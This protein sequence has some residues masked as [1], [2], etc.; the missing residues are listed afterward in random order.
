MQPATTLTTASV[1]DPTAGVST[2]VRRISRAAWMV[3][4]RMAGILSRAVSRANFK[5]NGHW[6]SESA[7]ITT[8]AS[9]A[10]SAGVSDSCPPPGRRTMARTSDEGE[11]E[12]EQ[13]GTLA[14][15]RRERRLP[16]WWGWW[17]WWD[18]T[19]LRAVGCAAPRGGAA[20]HRPARR[21]GTARTS[22]RTGAAPRQQ[23][24]LVAHRAAH[25]EVREAAHRPSRRGDS[26]VDPV[27]QAHTRT[28]RPAA[29]RAA[30]TRA[31]KATAT[32]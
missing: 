28:S 27:V 6:N 21:V 4:A 2:S 9:G 14:C 24:E 7:I 23:H 25:G 12:G 1:G 32:A 22:S 30:R 3:V 15:L 18:G 19:D 16:T 5:Q 20:Q 29:R 10:P 8:G 17:G 13:Q 26:R 11:G 31:T